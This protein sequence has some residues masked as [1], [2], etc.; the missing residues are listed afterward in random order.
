MTDRY[1]T[2]QLFQFLTEHSDTITV[3]TAKTLIDE[4]QADFV[5]EDIL[6]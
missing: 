5:V 1:N 4:F 2:Q 3:G 6:D